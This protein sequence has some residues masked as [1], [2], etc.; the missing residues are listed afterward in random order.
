MTVN[1]KFL[2]QTFLILIFLLVLYVGCA[3][4]PNKGVKVNSNESHI[5]GAYA[6]AQILDDST[7]KWLDHD[8]AAGI[9]YALVE[10]GKDLYAKGLGWADKENNLAMTDES[11]INVA[12]VSKF[13]SALGMMSYLEKNEIPL[14]TSINALLKKW[15]LLK[16][17][18]QLANEV[19]FEMLLGHSAG[20]NLPSV[21]WYVLGEKQPTLIEM[22]SGQNQLNERVMV[23][24]KPDSIWKYSGGAYAILE[25]VMEELTGIPFDAYFQKN[26]FHDIKVSHSGFGSSYVKGANVR[27][28]DT[29]NRPYAPYSYVGNAAAGFYTT[30][31]DFSE[32]M[33][34]ITDVSCRKAW[35]NSKSF[36]VMATPR[37][38]IDLDEQGAAFYGLGAGI[39]RTDGDIILYHSGSNEGVLAYCLISLNSKNAIFL[40]SNNTSSRPIFVRT[41]HLW[42]KHRDITLPPL[43]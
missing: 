19:T 17:N 33:H 36:E 26:V 43:Y 38:V 28:Y 30:A 13:I 34:C 23:T 32:I 5:R 15:K 11:V 4:K 9:V 3:F 10:N 39:F 7:T 20:V 2:F 18:G 42:A 22:L 6:S 16:A 29:A 37:N 35:L 27:Y 21:P 41:L 40:A 12:S 14:N 31:K 25:L 8:M 1:I 24:S